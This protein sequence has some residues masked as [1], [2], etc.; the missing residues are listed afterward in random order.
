MK[1]NKK[2]K[3]EELLDDPLEGAIEVP[4]IHFFLSC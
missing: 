4:F 1:M 2:K 3:I